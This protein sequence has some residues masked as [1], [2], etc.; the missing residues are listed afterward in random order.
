M[1][2]TEIVAR[3]NDQAVRLT[4]IPLLASGSEG[5]LKIKVYFDSLWDGYGKTAVF[6][7]NP[8]EVYHAIVIETLF[9]NGAPPECEVTVPAEVL[10]EEGYFYFGFMGRADN[11]RTTEVV[12]L[13]LAQGALIEATAEIEEPTPDIYQQLLAAYGVT[14]SRINELLATRSTGGASTHALSDEYIN[15]TIKTNGA[16]A[17]IDFTISKMSLDAGGNHYSDYCILPALAPLGPVEL[18]SSDPDINVTIEPATEESEGW[19]RILIEN[20][21][22]MILMTDQVTFV[23]GYYPLASLSIG[24]LA[25]IRVA[26][27]GTTYESAGDAVR[28]QILAALGG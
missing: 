13:E 1:S 4:N 28:A 11:T 18:N 19:A 6:Y 17:Y 2:Y 5:A 25:D 16:S 3:V 22:N 7:R 9:S 24:E 8:E 12:R 10:M 27:D 23:R 21:G 26:H 14:E 20:V 15:G